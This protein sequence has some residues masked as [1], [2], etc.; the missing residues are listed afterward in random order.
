MLFFLAYRF[1]DS[2][3]RDIKAHST[4]TNPQLIEIIRSGMK[5]AITILA[6]AIILFIVLEMAGLPYIGWIVFA[7]VMF[8]V[9]MITVIF[10]TT[11]FKNSISGIML[12]TTE[13]YN[14]GDRVMLLDSTVCD[15][16]RMGLMLTI[17]KTRNGEMLQIPNNE[18]LAHRMVNYTRAEYLRVAVR[19]E[20]AQEMDRKKAEDLLLK[21]AYE[22][23]GIINTNPHPEVL[24][25]GVKPDGIVYELAGHIR[26]FQKEDKIRSS[27]MM[28]VHDILRKEGIKCAVSA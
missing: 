26:N 18:I 8:L 24:V 21:A 7:I 15:I 23:D 22:T 28:R 16:V 4:R 11:P 27:L 3:L 19:V 13:P 14:V 1:I 10:I 9:A 12:M 25:K 6:S 20:L 5:Y 17:V 2:F